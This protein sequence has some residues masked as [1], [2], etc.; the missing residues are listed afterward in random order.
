MIQHTSIK[1]VCANAAC[2]NGKGS[3]KTHKVWSTF[4]RKPPSSWEEFKIGPAIIDRFS[5]VGSSQFSLD[6]SSDNFDSVAV[7]YLHEFSFLTSLE[8]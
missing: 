1:Y 3:F 6:T 2:F 5:V 4:L 7:T 8:F